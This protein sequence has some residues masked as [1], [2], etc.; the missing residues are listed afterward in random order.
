MDRTKREFEVVLVTVDGQTYPH[1]LDHPV[2]SCTPSGAARIGGSRVFKRL[3]Q[4]ENGKLILVIKET[5]SKT[6]GHYLIRRNFY[7][8]SWGKTEMRSLGQSSS[9]PFA[10]L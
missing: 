6:Y 10:R 5:G 3:H 4:D 7:G 8:R 1:P 2:Y 9:P